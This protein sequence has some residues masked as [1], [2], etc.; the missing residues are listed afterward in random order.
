MTFIIPEFLEAELTLISRD[1]LAILL[2]NY[3]RFIAYDLAID[4]EL[5][6]VPYISS[7]HLDNLFLN[8]PICSNPVLTSKN[9]LCRIGRKRCLFRF[10]TLEANAFVEYLTN[11]I[12]L[13]NNQHG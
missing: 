3:K 5:I 9:H 13:R 1:R 12:K 10:S 11:L 4:G 2:E 7:Q 6:T 8:H